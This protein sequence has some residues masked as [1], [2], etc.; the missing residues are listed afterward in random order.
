MY[1]AYCN[2]F[3]RGDIIFFVL[4]VKNGNDLA[5][6]LVCKEIIA[7]QTKEENERQSSQGSKFKT[8]H[9]HQISLE[10]FYK[11]CKN[12]RQMY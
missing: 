3:T 10:I 7:I 2:L 8:N 9:C 5:G 4:Y 1:S 11:W 12:V 6:S